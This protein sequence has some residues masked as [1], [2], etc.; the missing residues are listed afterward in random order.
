M[1]RG[2]RSRPPSGALSAEGGA[3][4]AGQQLE[5]VSSRKLC[6]IRPDVSGRYHEGVLWS[7]SYFAASCDGAPPAII[8]EYVRSQREG[9]LPP[10]LKARVFARKNDDRL[11]SSDIAS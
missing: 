7:A 8:A 3:L 4:Q 1:L 9:G 10:G 5:G 11:L 6:D 2:G